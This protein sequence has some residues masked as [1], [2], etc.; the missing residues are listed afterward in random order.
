[1]RIIGLTLY[2]WLAFGAIYAAAQNASR[3]APSS[4]C[5]EFNRTVLNQVSTG[6]L[7]DAEA[8][9]SRAL[10]SN[11]NGLEELCTGFLLHNMAVIMSASGR[12][13]EAE[14]FAE[15]SVKVLEKSYP[16]EDLALLRPLASLSSALLEQRKIGKARAVFQ[17]ML[18]VRTERP[19]DRAVLHTTAAALL[20]A[21][22]RYKD[23]ELEYFRALAAREEAGR[24]QTA[25]IAQLLNM[26]A[27]LYIVDKRF[28]EAGHILDRALAIFAVTGDGVLKDPTSLN[29][30]AAVHIHRG[31][32]RKAEEVLRSAITAADSEMR[33]DPLTLETLLVN[34]AYVLRKN[35][36]Q[37]EARA[38]EARAA[39]LY[40]DRTID[41][42]VD[43]SELLP[44]TKAAKK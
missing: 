24:G 32:W 39:T 35:H 38:A 43:A 15:R 5:I 11:A 17:R 7:A 41:P 16:P 42:V 19:D 36:R 22:A 18:S 4:A 30:Q 2:I 10:A 29:S 6:R 13:G 21:E 27:N 14:S 28:D 8:V 1:M 37:R 34:Y 44:K 9:L 20:Q 12:L 33:L 40:S 31:E 25:D 23:A 3:P 26:L